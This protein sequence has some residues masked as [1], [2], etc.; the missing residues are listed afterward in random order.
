[1]ILRA[2]DSKLGDWDGKR[3]LLMISIAGYFP[4][5]QPRAHTQNWGSIFGNCKSSELEV[6]QTYGD[7]LESQ[8]ERKVAKSKQID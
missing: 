4:L 5:R 1:M 8:E 6:L 3:W 7:L 2:V